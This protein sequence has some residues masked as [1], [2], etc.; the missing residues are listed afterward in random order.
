MRS[1]PPVNSQEFC[2][3]GWEKKHS[4]FDNKALFVKRRWAKAFP[5]F[6]SCVQN[7]IPGY[8]LLVLEQESEEI[9]CL[10]LSARNNFGIWTNLEYAHLRFEN[11]KDLDVLAASLISSWYKCNV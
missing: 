6:Y 5:S 2:K 8:I 9:Y 4:K 1:L 10:K 3:V 11:L 7:T